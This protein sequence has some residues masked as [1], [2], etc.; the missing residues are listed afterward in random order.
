M[1][2]A[3]CSTCKKVT[4]P[5]PVVGSDF[6]ASSVA[7]LVNVVPTIGV[8]S[9]L[10]TQSTSRETMTAAESWR[11]DMLDIRR[12]REYSES[13]RRMRMAGY[14]YDKRKRAKRARGVGLGWQVEN[15]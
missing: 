12:G 5:C 6:A 15:A 9:V 8:M 4:T 11:D 7:R 13:V 14:G 2:F 3:C 10:D 1:I